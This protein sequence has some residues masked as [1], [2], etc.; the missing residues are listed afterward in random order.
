MLLPVHAEE[1]GEEEDPR[2]A[3]VRP[4]DGVPEAEVGREQLAQR[5]LLGEDTFTRPL[6]FRRAGGHRGR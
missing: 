3:I 4:A 1:E 6:I 5:P 2:Q